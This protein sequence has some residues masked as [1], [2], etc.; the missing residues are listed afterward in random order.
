MQTKKSI[1]ISLSMI[2][3]VIHLLSIL[4]PL[5]SFWNYRLYMMFF[6]PT[7]L[8]VFLSSL[9]IKS[10][11]MG[12]AG[13][14]ITGV[15]VCICMYLGNSL[16][17]VIICGIICLIIC[18]LLLTQ[19][20]NSFLNKKNFG[21]TLISIVSIFA[22]CIQMN[23]IMEYFKSYEAFS[24]GLYDVPEYAAGMML[25]A[26]FNE[27]GMLIVIFC[28][29]FSLIAIWIRNSLNINLP[30]NIHKSVDSNKQI[31]M[32]EEKDEISEIL[33]IEP[34]DVIADIKNM[35]NENSIIINK[36]E[37]TDIK[38]CHKCG[39][40]L[41]EDSSFCSQCGAKIIQE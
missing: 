31:V 27:I 38:F 11:K 7:C 35:K 34:K 18:A 19:E 5:F 10:K 1:A 39:F 9:N 4:L 30:S 26:A 40:E 37:N 36:K 13:G 25:T 28:L 17:S 20:K 21:I 29:I 15:L 22:F 16:T 8:F 33:E 6:L 3:L 24:S 14:W 12:V 41:M 23:T 2:A 32:F